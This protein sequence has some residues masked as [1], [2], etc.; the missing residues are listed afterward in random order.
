[1]T[2]RVGHQKFASSVLDPG[3]AAA[4]GQLR[5]LHGVRNSEKAR[6]GNAVVVHDGF[7]L[8][9][10]E[11]RGPEARKLSGE[12][13]ASNRHSDKEKFRSDLNRPKSCEMSER[14]LITL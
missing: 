13:D 1:L 2:W 12:E 7:D 9:T 14:H 4:F 5:I 6:A 8:D 3:E 11:F 10:A